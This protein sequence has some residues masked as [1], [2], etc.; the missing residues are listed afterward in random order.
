[1]SPFSNDSFVEDYGSREG[2]DG[3]AVRDD[4]SH[5][6]ETQD[7]A[8][9]AGALQLNTWDRQA[10]QCAPS[11]LLRSSI[12]RPCCLSLHSS[13]SVSGEFRMLARR[14]PKNDER[15]SVSSLPSS[16]RLPP[17]SPEAQLNGPTTNTR[18]RSAR[19]DAFLHITSNLRCT[20]PTFTYIPVL[21]VLVQLRICSRQSLPS[22]VAAPWGLAQHCSP[23]IGT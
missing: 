10:P 21:A 8:D 3:T 15:E 6:Q 9:R 7:R 12:A 20:E 14:V 23:L 2:L 1:M 5:G 4:T 18:A 22:S 13:S 11:V 19:G 17:P 16:E